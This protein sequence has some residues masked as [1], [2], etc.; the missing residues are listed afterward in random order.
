MKP[1]L[2]TL[3]LSLALLSLASAQNIPTFKQNT[4]AL[5]SSVCD[6][7]TNVNLTKV[8]LPDQTNIFLQQPMTK[9]STNYFTT[10]NNTAQTGLYYYVTCGDLDGILTCQDTTADRGN[11]ERTFKVVNRGVTFT[12]FDLTSTLNIVIIGIGLLA[13]IILFIIGSYLISGAI[14]TILGLLFLFNSVS[15]LISIIIIVVGIV[16]MLIKEK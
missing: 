15:M 9:N 7:C 1:I 16:V 10:F 5:L 2:L 3:I 14:L 4:P 6:N 8:I 12:S 13:S 11:E